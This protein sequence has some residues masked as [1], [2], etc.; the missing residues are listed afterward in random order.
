ML[1]AEDRESA[2]D[3]NAEV[4]RRMR[5]DGDDLTKAR[6][7]DFHHLFALEQDAVD[8]EEA[9]RNQ[10]YRVT[11]DFWNEQDAWLTTVQ[12]RMVPALDEI[13]ATELE[14]DEIA[15]SFD[16]RPDGWGCMEVDGS[17]AS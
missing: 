15:R 11:H 3:E 5:E 17:R 9:L 13:T 14:L 12:I 2:V 1:G 4:L 10:G 16:G 7:I 8:F 6:H